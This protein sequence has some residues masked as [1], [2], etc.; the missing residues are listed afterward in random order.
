MSD[1]IRVTL[2][3][4]NLQAGPGEEVQAEI[5][6]QNA[7]LL[8]DA[9][10]IEVLDLDPGWFRLSSDNLPL[11]PGDTG[12]VNLVLRPPVGSD[13]VAQSYEFTINVVSSVDPSNQTSIG[14]ILEVSPVY[15]FDTSIFPEKVTG[16]AGSYNLSI[17]N[18]GN[19]QIIFDLDGSDPEGFCRFAFQPEQP[20]LP[21]LGEPG[22]GSQ[23]PPTPQAA[24]TVNQKHT[25]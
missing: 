4:D 11:F 1:L 21:P 13:A 3:P 23:R 10:S 20:V 8:V 14:S 15:S 22:C 6:V 2:Q 19:A 18:T 5:L 16:T 25:I 9:Y 24:F 12:T 7:G 17:Y